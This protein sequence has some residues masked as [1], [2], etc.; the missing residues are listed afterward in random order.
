MK[1]NEYHNLLE[2]TDPGTKS[3]IDKKFD[4]LKKSLGKSEDGSNAEKDEKIN[5][6]VVPGQSAEEWGETLII[7]DVTKG[8]VVGRISARG[9]LIS[10]PIVSG[11]S[12]SF[13]VQ[14]KDG[15]AL[16]T[17]YDL[18]DGSLNTTFRVG[19]PG[20]KGVSFDPIF[21]REEDVDQILSK[22][23]NEPGSEFAQTVSKISDQVAKK[24]AREIALSVLK[25]E[26]PPDAQI[27]A[28]MVTHLKDQGL[29]DDSKS[30]NA[31]AS[32]PAPSTTPM[33]VAASRSRGPSIT[34]KSA[35]PQSTEPSMGTVRRY[36]KM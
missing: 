17:T 4:E 8:I 13:A 22:Q 2:D 26:F 15:T 29:L 32:L 3:Y 34:I 35:S 27:F 36:F 31:G 1:F 30:D 25:Q 12:C 18:P 19:G 33:S 9:R 10:N 5:Y 7:T 21:K 11:N 24:D 16:G 20:S 6:V 28:Q 14:Q 23:L